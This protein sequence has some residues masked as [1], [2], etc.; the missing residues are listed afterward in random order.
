MKFKFEDEFSLPGSPE[1]IIASIP[2]CPSMTR[3]KLVGM[4]IKDLKS[5]RDHT[6]MVIDYTSLLEEYH[7]QVDDY[8]MEAMGI[9][10]EAKKH[11]FNSV[12]VYERG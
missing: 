11:H 1:D 10:A 3:E 5:S 9:I 2:G 8:E 4:A 12:K 7:F 6:S